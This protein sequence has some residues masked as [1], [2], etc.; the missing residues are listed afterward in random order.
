MNWASINSSSLQGGNGGGGGSSSNNFNMQTGGLFPVTNSN[1][2]IK[3]NLAMLSGNSVSLPPG[4][5]PANS[6]SSTNGGLSGRPGSRNNSGGD[7]K[8][9]LIKMTSA[10]DRTSASPLISTLS[11]FHG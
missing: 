4:V 9:Q 7:R 8:P 10:N 1:L 11:G 2:D 5:N 3:P 6:F